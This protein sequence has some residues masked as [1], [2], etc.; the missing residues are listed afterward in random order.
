MADA[1]S[2]TVVVR[3]ALPTDLPA[4][5]RVYRRSSWSNEGDRA[6]LTQHPEL[7]D[8]AETAVREGRTWVATAGGQ[9]VGFYSTAIKAD[10]VELE[11][12]FVDSD[13]MR[14]GVGRALIE[15]AAAGASASGS[16]AIEVDAN[17][18]AHSFYKSVGFT[19]RG[20][21]SVQYGTAMRMR[22]DMTSAQR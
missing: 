20:E 11:D 12:L 3:A 17:E 6:L 18:H 2:R 15:H 21:V 22:L 9:L 10:V 8:F 14:Q 16:A 19:D 5:R 13:W 1:R 7:L 4:L